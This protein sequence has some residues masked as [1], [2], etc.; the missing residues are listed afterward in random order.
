[1]NLTRR[2]SDVA[3][4]TNDQNSEYN[5]R[6]YRNLSYTLLTSNAQFLDPPVPQV[7]NGVQ[8]AFS[9]QFFDD[10]GNSSAAVTNF[11]TPPFQGEDYIIVA[12]SI[13][14]STC[15]VFSSYLFQ[16]HQ[17]RSAVF[18][19][20]PTA[21]VSQ[22]DGGVKG[23]EVTD[24]DTILGELQLANLQNDPAAPQPFPIQA[25]LT[26]NYR[27]AIPYIDKQDQI[28]DFVFEPGTKKYQF[29]PEMFNRP[30]LVWE[31]VA[32]QFFPDL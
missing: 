1:M 16:K 27:N 17:V 32:E 28:L 10:F 30:Q 23:S 13:C 7:V 18:G 9:H 22:F 3:A 12:N 20:T 4:S 26:Y 5:F 19:G 15:S 21:T 6:F 2:E 14:A 24:F 29:T 11:T 8:D 31:F 25:S